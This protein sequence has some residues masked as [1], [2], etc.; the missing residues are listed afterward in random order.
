MNGVTQHWA[1]K[2]LHFSLRLITQP[3]NQLTTANR[4]RVI[5]LDNSK[6]LSPCFGDPLCLRHQGFFFFPGDAVLR[7]KSLPSTNWCGLQSGHI[8]QFNTS[9]TCKSETKIVTIPQDSPSWQ[10]EWIS[11][12]KQ[13]CPQIMQFKSSFSTEG[14]K[15]HSRA[16]CTHSTRAHNIYLKPISYYFPICT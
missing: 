3:P 5:G 2:K 10:T 4:S 9:E 12:I 16:T 11:Y 7:N 6:Q 1:N 14:H 13:N 8:T 15:S